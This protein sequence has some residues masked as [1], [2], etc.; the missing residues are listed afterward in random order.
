[1]AELYTIS[2][3]WQ[4]LERRIISRVLD[5]I[6][7]ERPTAEPL[8]YTVDSAARLLDKTPMAVRKMIQRGELRC[9]RDGRR[10]RIPRVEIDRYLER[11][12]VSAL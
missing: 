12:G 9:V 5:V 1:M 2:D 4:E 11:L 10:V 8:V 3:P 7:A 6:R